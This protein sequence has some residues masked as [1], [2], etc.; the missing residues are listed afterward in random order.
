MSPVSPNALD[1]LLAQ[2]LGLAFLLGLALGWLVQRSHFCTLG[3]ISDWVLMRDAS[4]LR[5]WA[6]ALAVATLGLGGMTLAG[7]LSPLESIYAS[8]RFPWLSYLVGGLMFGSGMVLA[9]GCPSKN[10]VRLGA[11]NLKALVVLVVMGISALATLRGAPGLLR[12]RVLDPLTTGVDPGPFAGQWLASVTGLSV[13]QGLFVMAL[14]VSLLLVGWVLRS[15]DFLRTRQGLAGMGVGAVLLCMWWLS[16]VLGLVA[17]HPETLERVHLG[18]LSGRMEGLSFTAPLAHWLEAFIYQSEGRQRITLGMALVPGV[19]LGAA[20][21]AWRQGEFRWEG[22]TRTSDLARHLAGAVLMGI[23]GVTAMGCS[24]GQ[25]LTGLSTLNWGSMVA[26]V[27][28]VLGAFLALR[29]QWWLAV[30]HG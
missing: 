22:F 29:V 17:E 2:L 12:V 15:P 1:T 19:V 4:R 28:M 8:T 30:R 14:L 5:Q 3:A 6:L 18:T 24:F 9:S 23:G 20:L 26:V 25:G 7:W 27:A 21:G 10:L 16:G 13:P 11:G